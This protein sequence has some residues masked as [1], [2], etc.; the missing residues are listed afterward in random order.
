MMRI[1]YKDTIYIFIHFLSGM[2]IYFVP[3]TIIPIVG[4]HLLQYFMDVRFFGFQGEIRHGNS[5]EHTLVKLL[6]IYA[7]YL[8]IKLVYTP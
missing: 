7:G 4:Y 3:W 5:V 6:E 1:W 8:F 2:I